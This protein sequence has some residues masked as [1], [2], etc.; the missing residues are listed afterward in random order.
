MIAN[1]NAVAVEV[2]SEEKGSRVLITE[3][4]WTRVV[5][6]APAAVALKPFS[7]ATNYVVNPPGLFVVGGAQGDAGLTGR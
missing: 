6:P 2:I 3:Y 5:E 1:E 7:V 4:L